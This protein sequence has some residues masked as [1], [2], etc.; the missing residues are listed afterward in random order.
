MDLDG[1]SNFP[2]PNVL[3]EK[4]NDNKK[5]AYNHRFHAT[6]SAAAMSATSTNIYCSS[7]QLLPAVCRP[8][9]AIR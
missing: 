9:R 7:Q 4:N 5:C 3:A 6:T 8:I 2:L 1:N